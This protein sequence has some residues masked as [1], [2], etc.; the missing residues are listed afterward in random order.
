MEIVPALK[1]LSHTD[2][3]QQPMQLAKKCLSLFLENLLVCPETFYIPGDSPAEPFCLPPSP[4]C[5]LCSWTWTLSYPFSHHSFF[6]VWCLPEDTDISD[7]PQPSTLPGTQQQLDKANQWK[8]PP[9]LHQVLDMK[10]EMQTLAGKIKEIRDWL[11]KTK[12]DNETHIKHLS[13]KE[14]QMFWVSGAQHTYSHPR[15]RVFHFPYNS[16]CWW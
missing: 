1:G 7:S 3:N 4:I 2:L 8:P 5:A 6:V 10:G 11:V 16:N 13:R 14:R 9:L 15:N 12:Q